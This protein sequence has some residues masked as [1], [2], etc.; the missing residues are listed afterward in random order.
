MAYPLSGYPAITPFLPHTGDCL[1][2]STPVFLSKK[3]AI[4][5]Y[6]NYKLSRPA[7]LQDQMI[8]LR[9][10]RC[11]SVD[12]I[13]Y[14]PVKFLSYDPCPALVWVC[15]VDGRVSRCPRD[16]LFSTT[17]PIDHSLWTK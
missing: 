16:E 14:E 12:P 7:S 15:S 4:A 8:Y 17:S 10:K 1:G 5:M 11:F 13:K 6:T 2:L 3:G 9:I